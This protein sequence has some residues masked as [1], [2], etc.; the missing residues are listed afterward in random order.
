MYLTDFT[1]SSEYEIQSFG[2]LKISEFKKLSKK[3]YK[4]CGIQLPDIKL[5][6]VEGRLRKRVK[7]LGLNSFGD[8]MNYLF[9]SPG[10]EQ[11]LIPLIDAVTTNKTDFFR[12]S[13]HFDFLLNTV[14]SELETPAFGTF[15]AWSAGCST[16]EEAYTLA[17]V[18]NE[19]F[20]NKKNINFTIY[21]SDISTDVLKKAIDGIYSFETVEVIPM[22]LK[23]KYFL[24]SKD[25]EKH[26]ARI[27]PELRQQVIFSRINFMEPEYEIP[28]NLDVVFCR[29]VLIYFD[30]ETQAKVLYKICNKIKKGGFLF[31]GHSE[32]IQGMDLPLKRAA[33]TIYRR[34]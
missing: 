33:A 34:V 23:K 15:S 6:M 32:T 17:I 30:K 3:I 25:P 11:E 16:G 4:L 31:I 29:N 1:P 18:L 20:E 12:E 24:K 19:Y 27:R 9:S 13:I 28:E 8:Y 7:T 22:D 5:S 14:L 10:M 21:A 26:V 2:R